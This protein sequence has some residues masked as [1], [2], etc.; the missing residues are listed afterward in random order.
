MGYLLLSRGEREESPSMPRTPNTRTNGAAFDDA[1]VEAVWRKGTS[2]A[3][4]D[5]NQYRKDRC[6][7]L[8]QRDQYGKTTQYGWEI[9]HS[10]PVSS[11]GSDDLSNLQPLHWENNRYKGDNYPN[12]SCKV[13]TP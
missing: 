13:G 8:M 4:H 10:R 6:G 5:A 11:G 1:T 2:V 7:A 12:W 3:G 9:D